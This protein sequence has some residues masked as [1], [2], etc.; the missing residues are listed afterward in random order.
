MRLM[1][2]LT[3][4]TEKFNDGLKAG[5]VG[6]TIKQIL[7]DTKPEAA[8]FGGDTAASGAPSS[9]WTSKAR[10][11]SQPSPSRGSWASAPGSRPTWS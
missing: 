8:Y 11:T 2:R 1:L 3:F 10:P 9:W 7:E 6:P 5:T 4:P